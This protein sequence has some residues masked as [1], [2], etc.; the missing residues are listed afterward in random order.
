MIIIDFFK[1]HNYLGLLGWNRD[2]NDVIRAHRLNLNFGSYNDI[3]STIVYTDTTWERLIVLS[4]SRRNGGSR[5]IKQIRNCS[6]QVRYM[7]LVTVVRY[8]SVQKMK[9]SKLLKNYVTHQIIIISIYNEDTLQPPLINYY[10]HDTSI[11]RIK[12]CRKMSGFL[13]ILQNSYTATKSE[14]NIYSLNCYVYIFRS[15][16]YFIGGAT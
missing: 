4:I 6:S 16:V 11:G 10:F 14:N 12:Y 8:I 5:F 3:M 9:S 2:D 1:Q 7:R 15:I 13:T